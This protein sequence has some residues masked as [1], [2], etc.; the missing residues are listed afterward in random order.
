M[1]D[2]VIQYA[3]E[4]MVSFFYDFDIISMFT[5]T[6]VKLAH[7]ILLILSALSDTGF[8]LELLFESVIEYLFVI[9]L[10]N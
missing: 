3:T 6:E 10:V 8:L 2:F 7:L 9:F 4:R 5:K 1:R